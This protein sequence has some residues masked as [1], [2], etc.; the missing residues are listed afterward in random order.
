[1]ILS[2][3][4]IALF[5]YHTVWIMENRNE[6]QNYV[7][8]LHYCHSG[9]GCLAAM[10]N[11]PFF[12]DRLMSKKKPYKSHPIPPQV[13]V[14]KLY[15]DYGAGDELVEI[16]EG[17]TEYRNANAEYRKNNIYPMKWV[18]DFMPVAELA[19]WRKNKELIK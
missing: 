19:A 1:M 10:G 2:I 13:N 18:R 6:D 14:Q 4:T 17:F 15:V 7:D 16:C 5:T 9:L 12:G 8:Y 3:L 11:Y